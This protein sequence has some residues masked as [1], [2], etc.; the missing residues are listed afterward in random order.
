M[1]WS[2]RNRR[3][4]HD[5]HFQNIFMFGSC[6]ETRSWLNLVDQTVVVAMLMLPCVKAYEK[7]RFNHE[8][9]PVPSHHRQIFP[10]CSNIHIRTCISKQK[11]NCF[12]PSQLNKSSTLWKEEKGKKQKENIERRVTAVHVPYSVSWWTELQHI[13]TY[14]KSD[15]VFCFHWILIFFFKGKQNKTD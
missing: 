6:W 10:L 2:T 4:M 7:F 5:Y 1:V 13:T 14:I 12:H 15:A 9:M 8:R 11:K 3:T